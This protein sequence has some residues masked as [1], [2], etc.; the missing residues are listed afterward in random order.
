M[1]FL[2]GAVAPSTMAPVASPFLRTVL[3]RVAAGQQHLGRLGSREATFKLVSEFNTLQE[4]QRTALVPADLAA[5]EG[6]VHGVLRLMYVACPYDV[7]LSAWYTAGRPRWDDEV[8]AHLNAARR[9]SGLTPPWW[10]P[11]RRLGARRS[12]LTAA[13]QHGYKCGDGHSWSRFWDRVWLDFT[14]HPWVSGLN[15]LTAPISL[16]AALVCR[17]FVT[18]RCNS[19]RKRLVLETPVGGFN[20]PNYVTRGRPYGGHVFGWEAHMTFPDSDPSLA[21]LLDSPPSKLAVLAEYRYRTD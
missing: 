7:F 8:W 6:A 9:A 17:I 18:W 4:V 10:R 19:E 1:E 21:S 16:P 11:F 12:A 15:I 20:A 2:L 5:L 3:E 14:W 13:D